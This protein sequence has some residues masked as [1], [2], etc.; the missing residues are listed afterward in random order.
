MIN[1]EAIKILDELKNCYLGGIVDA[2]DMAIEAVKAQEPITGETSDG[3]HTFNELYHHRAVLFSVI[4]NNYKDLAWKS[5]RHHDGTMYDG[6]FIVGI[7]T[8]D[9]QATYHYDIDPYWDMFDCKIREFAPEWDGHTPAQAIERIGKLK[10][11]EPRVMTIQEIKNADFCYLEVNG[12]DDVTPVLL[13]HF[14]DDKYIHV[15]INGGSVYFFD[16]TCDIGKLI[17][18]WTSRPTYEQ[19]EATPWNA[20]K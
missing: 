2:I 19:R 7:D 8:P 4:V 16:I 20:Q 17:R 14:I 1:Q 6:M 3:Y 5:V 12:H 18:C 11:R 13:K 10:A 15:T 9:G